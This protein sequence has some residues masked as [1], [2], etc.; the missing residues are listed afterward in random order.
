MI[1]DWPISFNDAPRQPVSCQFVSVPGRV[2]L[3]SEQWC[4]FGPPVDA[5]ARV[6]LGHAPPRK[7]PAKLRLVHAGARHSRVRDMKI[8]IRPRMPMELDVNQ[9]CNC[10][11][12]TSVLVPCPATNDNQN[13]GHSRRGRQPALQMTTARRVAIGCLKEQPRLQRVMMRG[14]FTQAHSHM[15]IMY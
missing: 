10:V 9:H 8:A 12:C 14:R 2:R 4:L 1:V 5:P 3:R 6:V 15:N 13:Y 11:P 7:G